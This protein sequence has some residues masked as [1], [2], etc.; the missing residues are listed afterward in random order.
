M[1]DIND[2][3]LTWRHYY[4]TGV[5]SLGQL[6][7]TGLA[8]LVSVIIPLYQL[9]AHPELSSVMQGLVG[10][11]DL[12]GIM[13]GSVIIGKLSDHFGYLIFFRL[14]PLLI[15]A[16][17]LIAIYLSDIPI[18]II[19]LFFMGFAIGGEYSLD[20][21]YIST[22]MPDKWKSLMVGSAKAASA[23][24]N[25]GVAAVCFLM[26][27]GWTDASLWPRLLW[28]MVFISGL[29][30]LLRIRFWESPKWLLTH[31]KVKKAEQSV[32]HFLGN[33]VTIQLPISDDAPKT[34]NDNSKAAI[35]SF[36]EFLKKDWKKIIFTG[37]PWACEGL[38]VYGIGV[39]LPILVMALGLEHLSPT[40][41]PIEHV[42]SS[43]EIT[44]WISCIILP[45]FVIGLFLINRIDD[46]K[47]QWS[48]FLLSGL[49][50]LILLLAYHYHWAKWIAIISFMSFELFLNMGPH[51]ITYV[52]PPKVYPI[53]VRGLG[54]GMAASIGK[55][56]AVL[57][58]FFIPLLLDA[59]GSK[60]VLI[61]SIIVMLVGAAITY[62]FNPG[63]NRKTNIL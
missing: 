31:G 8:T 11:M 32:K 29:M 50:L 33:S 5:A 53:E 63:R 14:C 57:G 26:V 7:G 36:G 56:G 37:I 62:I 54:S 61:V 23:F 30:F 16:V 45:G 38:G 51:L 22:L 12:I 10:A 60:L 21:N 20:S 27:K 3:P 19:C 17:S 9:V 40:E 55:I 13:V 25:I 35:P 18:L 24:G 42:A 43:V 6:I 44:L 58:V 59:G 28:I 2:A 47:L 41:Q 49:S 4:I 1:Y 39:F 15:C 46:A 34:G 48:G 52:L